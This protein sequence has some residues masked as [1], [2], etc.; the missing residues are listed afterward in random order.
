MKIHCHQFARTVCLYMYGHRA[1]P[2]VTLRCGKGSSRFVFFCCQSPLHWHPNCI[3]TVVPF[4]RMRWARH[5]IQCCC[6][7]KHSLDGLTSAV[8]KAYWG[9]TSFLLCL[10]VLWVLQRSLK[11]YKFNI[12]ALSRQPAT[13]RPANRES[14]QLLKWL[15]V[16]CS[17]SKIPKRW[18]W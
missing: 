5:F 4:K 2:V 6:L 12:W 11:L 17:K 18:I 16:V 10:T 7:S 15:H 8:F 9:T 3:N 1:L 13:D 14:I